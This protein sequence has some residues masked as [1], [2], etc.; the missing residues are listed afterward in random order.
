MMMVTLIEGSV[1]VIVLGTILSSFMGLEGIRIS[2]PRVI[3]LR[4]WKKY[5][6]L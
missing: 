3:V 2:F 6:I 5:L 1:G 4:F